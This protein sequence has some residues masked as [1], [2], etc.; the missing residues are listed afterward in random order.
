MD[1]ITD[2][3]QLNK[4]VDALQK[5]LVSARQAQFRCCPRNAWGDGDHDLK[6]PYKA[7][8]DELEGLQIRLQTVM[9]LAQGVEV[10]FENP[11][12]A[13]GI[14]RCPAVKAVHNLVSEYKKLVEEK[15]E[16]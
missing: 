9:L 2:V 1:P 10:S 4:M 15:K 8:T 3:D 5:E 16:S 14:R 12:L 11:L 13:P 6:C 7:V